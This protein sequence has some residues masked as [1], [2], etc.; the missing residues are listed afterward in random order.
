[1][2]EEAYVNYFIMRHEVYNTLLFIAQLYDLV[3]Q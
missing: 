2:R 1:M 3:S